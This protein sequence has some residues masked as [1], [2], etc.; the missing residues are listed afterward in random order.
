MFSP[1]HIFLD[2]LLKNKMAATE[3]R[4]VVLEVFLDADEHWSC[5]QLYL[6]V[7]KKDSTISS[8]TVYR[9]VKLLVESGVAEQLCFGDGVLRFEPRFNRPHH[10]HFVCINCKKKIDVV[11]ERIEKLQQCLAEKHGFLLTRHKMI[12]Y[13]VCSDCRKK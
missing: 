7:I 5:E 12:L 10:D 3:Q 4:R 9:T 1:Q 13:G 6:E 8:A 11:D 2:Y